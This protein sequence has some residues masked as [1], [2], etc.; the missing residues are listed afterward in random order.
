[1]ASTRMAI[2]AVLGTVND[3][4]NT[5]SSIVNVVSDSAGMLNDYVRRQRT[6]Q[7]DRTVIELHTF[8]T[9]LMEDT[10]KEQTIRT[11]SLEDYFQGKTG[12]KEC[13]EES[14]A[15]LNSLFAKSDREN[16]GEEEEN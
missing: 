7:Q 16:N 12:R 8:R 1:M 14:Y 4:A 11:E 15:N 13:Y 5:V 2:G 6:M 3:A 9:R 10:A